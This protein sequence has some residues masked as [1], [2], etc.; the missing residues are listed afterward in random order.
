MRDG[1]GKAVE[2][3]ALEDPWHEAEPTE[4]FERMRHLEPLDVQVPR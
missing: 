1:Q 4:I 2:L 3:Q